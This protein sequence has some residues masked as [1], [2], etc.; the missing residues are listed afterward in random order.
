MDPSKVRTAVKR[1]VCDLNDIRRR[2]EERESAAKRDLDQ[3]APALQRKVSVLRKRR[4]QLT[5]ELT[6]RRQEE[7]HARQRLV[8]LEEAY[9]ASV[10]HRLMVSALPS[11]QTLLDFILGDPAPSDCASPK[12]LAS[13]RPCSGIFMEVGHA[14]D[15]AL[16]TEKHNPSCLAPPASIPTPPTKRQAGYMHGMPGKRRRHQ[17][18]AMALVE[19]TVGNDGLCDDGNARCDHRTIQ[20]GEGWSILGCNEHHAEFLHPEA[21]KLCIDAHRAPPLSST[22]PQNLSGAHGVV[23]ALGIDF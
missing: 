1:F 5:E 9:N 21:C 14:D 8:E 7:D 20:D 2:A 4:T 6:A 12:P 17:A 23:G 10:Q 11:T 22:M 19:E 3:E 15:L 18:S 16:D 13:T